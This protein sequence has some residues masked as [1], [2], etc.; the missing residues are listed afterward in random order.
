M[1]GYDKEKNIYI[2]SW[3]WKE[4]PNWK[5]VLAA[6]HSFDHCML[7]EIETN[8]DEHAIAIGNRFSTEADAIESYQKENLDYGYLDV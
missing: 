3:D 5:E 2:H 4:Q 8:S 6:I 7:F 1:T